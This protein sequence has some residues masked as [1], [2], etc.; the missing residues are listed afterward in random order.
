MA[1]VT[2]GLKCAPDTGPKVR[3]SATS[4]APVAMAFARSATATLPAASRSPMIPEPTTAISKNAVPRPSVAARRPTAR[5]LR[6]CR[7]H[8]AYEGAHELFI[9]L[10]R[11]CVHIDARRGE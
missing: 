10:G 6:Q 2:T 3:I 7:F 8:R 1:N 5:L 9:D 11:D 4:A